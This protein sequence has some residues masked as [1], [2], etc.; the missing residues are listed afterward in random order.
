MEGCF[1]EPDQRDTDTKDSLI[2]SGSISPHFSLAKDGVCLKE[3]KGIQ[4]SD[5][6]TV[7][8]STLIQSAAMF[9]SCVMFSV[10]NLTLVVF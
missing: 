8:T 6:Q 9:I 10:F 4:N 2:Y 7:K 5:E 3:I 1:H